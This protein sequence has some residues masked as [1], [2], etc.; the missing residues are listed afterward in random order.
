MGMT[1]LAPT[2]APRIRVDTEGI[3]AVA[4]AERPGAGDD[5]D[6]KAEI[7]L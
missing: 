4:D 2:G 3:R 1:M 6:A 5:S 7:G